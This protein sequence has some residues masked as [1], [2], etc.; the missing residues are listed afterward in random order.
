MQEGSENRTF[1]PTRLMSDGVSCAK[2]MKL[3]KIKKNDLL[4]IIALFLISIAAFGYYKYTY[5]S[6]DN[7]IR[8][9]ATVTDISISEYDG[10]EITYSYKVNGKLYNT[11]QCN[12]NH[13]FNT[14]NTKV[15][16]KKFITIIT[17]SYKVNGKLYNTTQCNKNYLFNT[18]NTKVGDKKF[19]TIDKKKPQNIIPL[20]NR[21]DATYAPRVI[22]AF[23]FILLILSILGCIMDFY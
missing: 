8:V 2:L 9:S 3:K 17:Y 21:D 1:L 23:S 14:A 20:E 11:T 6:Y 22:F 18:A 10:T 5:N 16:D 15:G 7:Y 4:F 19:I 13:L 12:K